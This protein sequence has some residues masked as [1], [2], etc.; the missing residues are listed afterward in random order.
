MMSLGCGDGFHDDPASG[1]GI[2]RVFFSASE[3]HDT[4]KKKTMDKTL[5]NTFRSSIN[6]KLW[7]FDDKGVF[8]DDEDTYRN[9]K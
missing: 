6:T 9:H 1:G 5:E 7:T 3:H 4:L 2:E 8:T